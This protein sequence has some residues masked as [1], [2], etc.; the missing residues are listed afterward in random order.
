[1]CRRSCLLPH[2]VP[3]LPACL[4]SPTPP[5]H[6]PPCR[7]SLALL[8]R[9][10]PFLSPACLA[11]PLTLRRASPRLPACCLPPAAGNIAFAP[12]DFHFQEYTLPINVSGAVWLRAGEKGWWQKRLLRRLVYG[13]TTWPGR[14]PCLLPA[15]AGRHAAVG[16]AY[17]LPA[18]HPELLQPT[19]RPRWCW[20]GATCLG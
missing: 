12:G 10:P 18:T 16:P 5:P 7:P 15:A 13:C 19:R 4:P 17:H 14:H 3:A 8:T 9:H 20:T 11:C 1:M 2:P 6:S